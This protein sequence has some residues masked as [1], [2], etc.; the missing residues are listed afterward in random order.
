M[1]EAAGLWV[2]EPAR[3]AACCWQGRLLA[4]GLLQSGAHVGLDSRDVEEVG[5]AVIY[6]LPPSDLQPYLMNMCSRL[7][8]AA[9]LASA[10]CPC[11]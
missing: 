10:P 3:L 11:V 4:R 6:H 1:Q 7:L 9:A 8:V 2:A 5:V